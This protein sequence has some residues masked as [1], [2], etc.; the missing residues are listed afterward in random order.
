MFIM[1]KKKVWVYKKNYQTSYYISLW[2]LATILQLVEFLNTIN[3]KRYM[4]WL[5]DVKLNS[6]FIYD[7]LE[8]CRVKYIKK[9][10]KIYSFEL[11]F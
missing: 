8:L 9:F 6:S 1:E 3:Y 4:G 2:A 7:H 11:L 5:V 10:Y